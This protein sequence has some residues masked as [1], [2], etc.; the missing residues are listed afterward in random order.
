MK[1]D[2]PLK[3]E[4]LTEDTDNNHRISSASEI[5]FVMN[6][7]AANG[8]RVALYHGTEHEFILTTLLAADDSG[9]WLEESPNSSDN[10]R[11]AESNKLVFVSSHLQVKVQF[12]ARQAN[13]VAYQGRPAFYLPMP[14]NLYRLQRREYFRLMTPMTHPLRCIIDKQAVPD[15]KT[16]EFVITDISCG[17]IGLSCMASDAV[18]T[19]GLSYSGCRVELPGLGTIKGT[20]VIK[21]LVTLTSLSGSVF[22]R[23]GCE[24]KNLDGSSTILLQRY[25]TN[26][27]RAGNHTQVT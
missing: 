2:I 6:Y 22:R 1:K 26:M 11:V 27:Q 8:N 24:F 18:L 25:V 9:L 21:N 4:I 17:G 5:K 14:D 12:T 23:A 16:L 7:I 15:K 13:R 10:R 3:I 20:V 19:P